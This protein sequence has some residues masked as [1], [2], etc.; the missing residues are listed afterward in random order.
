M[1]VLISSITN[2]WRDGKG[3]LGELGIVDDRLIFNKKG[4][5]AT[6]RPRSIVGGIS[7]IASTKY[8]YLSMPLSDIKSAVKGRF[9]LN[10]KALIVT[11]KDDEVI[12]F[13]ISDKHNKWFTLMNELVNNK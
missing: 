2:M 9:R 4:F 12:I 13:A 5:M 8:E 7:Q 1:E 11:T 10:S 3:V 6:Y